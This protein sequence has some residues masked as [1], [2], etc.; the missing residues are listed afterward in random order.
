MMPSWSHGYTKFGLAM[1]GAI[2]LTGCFALSLA[3]ALL[4]IASSTS[5]ALAQITPDTTLGNQNSTVTST[6][7][8]DQI[9]GGVTRGANLFHSFQEF[10]VGNGRTALFS[11]PL[12]IENILSRV[13]GANPSNILGTLGVTGGNANLFLI[14]PNGIIFGQNARLSLNG[15]FVATTANAIGLTNGDIFSANPVEPLPNQL[16]NVNPNAFLFNQIAA[17]PI[18]NRSTADSRGLQVPQGQ[19]LLMVGGDVKLEGGILQAPGGRVELGG[20][21]GIGTVGL[22][23]NGNDLRLSFPVGV[24]LADVSLNNGAEVNVRAGGGGSIAIN[25]QNLNIGGAS[26]LLA[27]IDSGLGS[28]DSIAGDIEINAIETINLTNES[29]I[30]NVVLPGVVG[31]GGNVNI[32]TGALLV[33]N[34]AQLFADTYG[35]GDAGSVN[36]T[37]HDTVSFDGV[38]SNGFL[39]GAFSIVEAEAVGKG[40]GINIT[41]GSLL[42]MNG[43]QLSADT[44]GQGDA[45]SVNITARDT[46]SFDE[47]SSNGYPSGAFSTVEAGA[48][49]KGGDINI[50]TRLLSVTNGAVLVTYVSGQG[51]TGS[52][53]ISARDSVFFNGV[54][55]NGS[56]SGVFNSV[57]PGVVGNSGDIN[58]TT[59]SLSVT[60]G[61]VLSTT[62]FGQ[63]DAGSVNITARDTVS[64]NGLSKDRRLPSAAFSNVATEGVGKGGDINITTGSLSVTNGAQLTSSTSGQG[65]SGSVN[66]HARDTVSFDGAVFGTRFSSAAISRVNLGAIGK[67][68]DINITTGSL[69]V[70]NGAELDAS[71]FGQGDGG[72]VNIHARD[73][74]SFNGVGSNGSPS[75]AY[76]TVERGAVGNGGGINISTWLL[77]LMNGAQLNAVTSVQGDGGNITLNANTLEAVNGGQV[78]TTSFSS[79]KAGNIILNVTDSVTLYGSDPTYLD[80]LSR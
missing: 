9:N 43:A 27:G 64:F 38:G 49:G 29:L 75:A 34:G 69:S 39:S 18:I 65:D 46:V 72:S 77:S 23:V 15:S 45:G 51:N 35:Q 33:I 17:Q 55:S 50:T 8:V 79:G 52:V 54:D 19:S 66:I 36:I 42:V 74:V 73:T 12:G 1:G 7:A 80:R 6:G 21:A 71:S 44:H 53:N 58:I 67:G 48:V 31:K 59:G 28:V 20:V 25:A 26:K 57:N 13:T 11:N 30:A 37:A 22:S 32:T 14:N 47:T 3:G 63:G 61:A 56:R 76:S 5:S 4:A 2:T 62:T 10:N 40:G 78:L 16:L 24:Q 70:T 68:G 60:N 41:T